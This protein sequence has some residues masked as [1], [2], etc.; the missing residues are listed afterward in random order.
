M[1]S[2]TRIHWA[3][4]MGCL[5][6]VLAVRAEPPATTRPV[7]GVRIGMTV[8]DADR[9]IEFYT[10]VLDFEKVADT[11][12]A[13]PELERLTGVFGARCRAVTLRLGAEELTLTE[14]IASRGRA[15]PRDSRS[16]DRW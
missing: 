15:I 2:Q 13:G 7:T 5:L 10:R 1:N 12:T 14:F 3:V 8:E 6:A 16:N 9:S 4:L 11:E